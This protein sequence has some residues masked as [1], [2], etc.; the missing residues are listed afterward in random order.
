[1]EELGVLILSLEAAITSRP[2]YPSNHA[3]C[4]VHTF[5]YMPYTNFPNCCL[6]FLDNS[7]NTALRYDVHT[8]M[9]KIAAEVFPRVARCLDS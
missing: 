1:M 5:A 9:Y 4:Y 7:F 3:L 8:R 6:R 2:P